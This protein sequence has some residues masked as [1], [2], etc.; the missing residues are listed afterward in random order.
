MNELLFSH[1][2]NGSKTDTAGAD[3][4]TIPKKDFV[5]L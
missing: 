5:I 2:L 1:A 4:S 3:Q